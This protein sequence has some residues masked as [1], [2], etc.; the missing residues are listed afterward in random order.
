M[1]KLVDEHEKN[2]GKVEERQKTG[3]GVS[4]GFGLIKAERGVGKV[5]EQVSAEKALN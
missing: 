2:G 3:G 4:F 1:C 5:A